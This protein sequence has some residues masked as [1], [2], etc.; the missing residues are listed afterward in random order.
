MSRQLS[1]RGRREVHAGRAKFGAFGDGKEVAQVALAHAFQPG[2]WR[3][4]YYRDQTLMFAL[5]LL[6]PESYF[7]QLYAHTDVQADPASGGRA[8]LGHFASRLLDNDGAFQPQVSTFNIAADIS[9]TAGQMPRLVGLAHA[10]VI[11]REIEALHALTTFSSRGNEIAFGMIGN[12]S[13]AE[14]LFWEAINAIGVLRAPAVISIWDDG[15]GISVPNDLAL[16]GGDLSALLQGF[17]RRDDGPGYDLYT[18]PGW[19]YAHL[20]DLYTQAAH[21]ARVH[22]IPAL[23]HVTEMTQPQGH[24]TSGSHKRYKPA[25]RLA[26]EEAHD[27]IVRM[28]AWLLAEGLTDERTLAALESDLEA[29]AQAACE[30]AWCAYAT[31]RRT[32]AATLAALLEEVMA[33]HADSRREV[34]ALADELRTADA[35]LHRQ[36]QEA[37]QRAIFAVRDA[38]G[39]ACTALVA[40]KARHYAEQR[41]GY[42]EH[43]YAEGASAARQVPVVPATYAS[44]PVQVRG[45][46]VL[47]ANF[48]AQLARDPRILIFGEDVGRMGDVNQGVAGLQAKYGARRVADA[49]IR[50]ATIVGQAI[51]YAL[52]G[53]RPI[54]EI[55]YLDYIF[56]ALMTLTDDLATLHWRT[57]GGQKAPA[58]IRTR[59][60]RLEGI[61]HAGSPLGALISSLRG[62]YICAPRNMTQAAGFYNTL[63]RGDDPALVIEVLNGYRLREPMPQ[64]LGEFTVPLGVPEVLRPGA[65]VTVVTYGACCRIVLEAAQ[66]LKGVGVESEVIDVQTLLPFDRPGVIG[67]SVRK[68]GRVVF[69]DEDAGRRVRVHAATGGGGA[70]RVLASRQPAAHA[71]RAS[72]SSGLWQRRRLFLQTECRRCGR[73]RLRLD[74]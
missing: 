10:S 15:Y 62:L 34:A 29:E 69:V 50:E 30:R 11:Y 42:A 56:Y 33:Q 25:A 21:N 6:T 36:M 39:P 35:P 58:I 26:W 46:E 48:D 63:L 49:G 57:A 45:F 66:R 72:A 64:N 53:L 44:T 19:D 67:E 60:H 13:C 23:V 70:G 55:Q 65:D 32:A 7:A 24:S 18:A 68:T 14:G 3:S 1:L 59:G 41:A 52:R 5:G 16:M 22:H 2:D 47:Q 51:G 9:P 43:L 20:V 61:W 73:S 17:V 4:G 40:W 8:M 27:P 74:A 12:A 38:D 37:A 31:P 71:H 28:R 54:A